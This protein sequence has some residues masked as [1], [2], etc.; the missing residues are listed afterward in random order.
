MACGGRDARGHSNQAA[1]G[2]HYL[3]ELVTT[4][5]NSRAGQWSGGGGA[6]TPRSHHE[7]DCTEQGCVPGTVHSYLP[8]ETHDV[9]R[10]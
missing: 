3:N 5:A 7:V 9:A 8:Q 6:H 2:A 10:S 1:P 4:G